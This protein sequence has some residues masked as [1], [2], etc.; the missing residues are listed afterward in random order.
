MKSGTLNEDKIEEMLSGRQTD[1]HKANLVIPE[2]CTYCILLDPVP[3]ENR[4]QGWR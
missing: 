2:S 1:L 3:W 4:R